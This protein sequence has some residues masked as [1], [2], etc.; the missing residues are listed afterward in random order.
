MTIA[1]T[2]LTLTL[3][4]DYRISPA[5][6]FELWTTAEHLAAWLKPSIDRYK[7]STCEA[8]ARVG[9]TYRLTIPGVTADEDD[10]TAYGTYLELDPPRLVR[11]TWG[12]ED[13]TPDS[14][15]VT[16]E[17]SPTDEGCHVVLTHVRLWDEDQRDRHAAGWEG[18]LD[19]LA[20]L[21][22]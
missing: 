14:T 1:D 12:W 8:D 16:V 21:Y 15:E 5:R 9:G 4:R 13:T 22:G 10:M 18:S 7:T 2:G 11:F 17:I 20:T 3:E 6:M 19:S